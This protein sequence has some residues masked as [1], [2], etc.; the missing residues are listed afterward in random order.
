MRK[1]MMLTVAM[2]ALAMMILPAAAAAQWTNNDAT[3]ATNARV[4]TTGQARFQ[5]EAVGAVECQVAAEAQLTAATTTGHTQFEVDT[6]AGATSTEACSVAG[7]LASLGCTD[8]SSVTIEGLPWTFH[9]TSTQ[10]VS[11]TTGTIQTHLHGGIFCP[12]TQQLT[13]G[14]VHITTS[15]QNTW[16]TGQL[17]GTLKA[18]S[19]GVES[20]VN[21]IGHGALIPLVTTGIA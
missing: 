13:P 6:R 19:G 11:V 9:A 10:T 15:T 16:N 20:Q 17:S 12:K 18:H 5:G 8:V 4:P 3:L 7:P 1:K 2:A 21:I 14:T